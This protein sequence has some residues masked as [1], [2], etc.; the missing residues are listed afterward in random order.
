MEILEGLLAHETQYFADPFDPA[1]SR[2]HLV[3]RID[4]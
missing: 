4:R 2:A 1:A 3:E